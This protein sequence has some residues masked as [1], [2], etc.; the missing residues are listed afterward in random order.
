ME[1]RR[2]Q[3]LGTYLSGE[4]LGQPGTPETLISHLRQLT[5]ADVVQTTAKLMQ[6]IEAV[7]DRS[8]VERQAELLELYPPEFREDLRRLLQDPRGVQVL[9]YP[10]Q[11]LS[12]QK[13]A[14]KYGRDEPPTSFANGV[15][16]AFLLAAAQVGDVSAH[17]SAF[18]FSCTTQAFVGRGPNRRAS[19][20]EI[21]E[22]PCQP[23]DVL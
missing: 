23:H 13:L 16:G 5:I 11:L 18:S 3:G 14:L 22:R 9:F 7:G 21:T 6:H 12:L 4:T 10:Q 2:L 15:W 1:R 19:D 8:L 17:Y 20:L